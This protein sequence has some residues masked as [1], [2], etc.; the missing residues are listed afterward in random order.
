[1][2]NQ[3]CY[4]TTTYTLKTWNE[5][6]IAGGR[7]CG[8]RSQTK[9]LFETLCVGDYLL[10]YI[11]KLK[12][13]IGVQEVLSKVFVSDAPIWQD[14]VFPYRVKVKT[15][16]ALNPETAV[17][18]SELADRLSNFKKLKNPNDWGLY[19]QISPRKWTTEDGKEVV[20]AIEAALNSPI[21][22]PF[23]ATKFK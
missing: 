7:I 6:Q 18:V 3:R 11:L 19:F 10:C 22:R 2:D 21:N 23:D 1:M 16:M 14:D 8:F 13:F 20:L 5:G 15:L 9:T 4:W 17:P 12:R